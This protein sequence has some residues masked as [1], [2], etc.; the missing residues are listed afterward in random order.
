MLCW[1]R[2]PIH[3]QSSSSHQRQQQNPNHPL[4]YID[5]ARLAMCVKQGAC[6]VE[7]ESLA[8]KKKKR[9]K[10]GIL[11]HQHHPSTCLW[12]LWFGKDKTGSDYILLFDI[13]EGLFSFNKKSSNSD[14]VPQNSTFF[15]LFDGYVIWQWIFQYSRRKEPVSALTESVSAY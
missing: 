8:T 1:H 5:R 15:H 11:L 12:P 10:S 13:A 2:H 6:G 14:L 3:L 4:E 9:S 7:T